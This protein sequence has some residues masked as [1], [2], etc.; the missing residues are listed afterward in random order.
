MVNLLMWVCCWFSC[1]VSVLKLVCDGFCVI[2]VGV[3]GVGVDVLLFGDCIGCDMWLLRLVKDCFS[4][5]SLLV[6]LVGMFVV[7][8]FEGVE[9]VSV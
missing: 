4:V 1:V 8:V 5:V 3:V 6:I 7:V 2:G 9:L